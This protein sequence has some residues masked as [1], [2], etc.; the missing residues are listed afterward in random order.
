MKIGIDI[1]EPGT[2]MACLGLYTADITKCPT[3][4]RL[5]NFRNFNHPRVANLSRVMKS[6]LLI[7]DFYALLLIMFLQYFIYCKNVH[8]TRFL[9]IFRVTA[10]SRQ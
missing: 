7:L 1:L 8:Q 5:A 4:D 9:Q 2:I 3:D 6:L 10:R